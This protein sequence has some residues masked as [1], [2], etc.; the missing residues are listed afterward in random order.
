[1]LVETA[2]MEFQGRDIMLFREFILQMLFMLSIIVG[3]MLLREFILQMLFMLSI[4]VG[5]II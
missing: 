1:M 2:S 4:I 5:L 3:L